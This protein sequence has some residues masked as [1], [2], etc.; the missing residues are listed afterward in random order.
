MKINALI[1]ARSGS[2]RIKDKNIRDF[3]GKPLMAWSIEAALKSGCFDNVY[4]STDS[5][6]YM[7]IA[8]DH[9]ARI[10]DRGPIEKNGELDMVHVVINAIGSIKNCDAIALLQPTSPFRLPKDV[11]SAVDVYKNTVSMGLYSV[12]CA[13]QPHDTGF[14]YI[15]DREY[16]LNCCQS[17][18][19]SFNFVDHEYVKFLTS[20][21]K[22]LQID[23]ED[24]WKMCEILMK[25]MLKNNV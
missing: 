13:K 2:K 18:F 21:P 25:E 22:S 19:H 16:F 12:C 8:T 14:I 9:G 7:E 15:F 20:V 23:T 3:C 10:I 4:V 17:I 1:P 11:C 6:K 5:E 24:D